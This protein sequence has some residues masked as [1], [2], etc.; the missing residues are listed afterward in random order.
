MSSVAKQTAP[1]ENQFK[2]LS[3]EK[4]AA[5]NGA[6]GD[7]WYKYIVARENS[8]IVGNMRGSL[9][10]VTKYAKEFVENLNTRASMPKGRST[11]APS[12]SQKT[13]A[14]KI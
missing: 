7:N 4:T 9:Q 5:P 11:W 10:Q 2:V 13:P 6:E 3:V 12:P 1:G 14:K 8:E